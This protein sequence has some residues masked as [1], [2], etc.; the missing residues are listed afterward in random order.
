MRNKPTPDRASS[1]AIADP[2]APHPTTATRAAA[3]RFCPDAPMP[4]NRICREYRS[5]SAKDIT[6]PMP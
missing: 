5:S 3:S 4:L 1:A 6:N 2:V